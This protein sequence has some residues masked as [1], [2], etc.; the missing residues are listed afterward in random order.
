MIVP[1]TRSSCLRFVNQLCELVIS[2]AKLGLSYLI[3]TIIIL[4]I[5]IPT[6]REDI[7]VIVLLLVQSVVISG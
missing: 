2:T 1:I 5:L 6:L 7:N 4:I 3:I